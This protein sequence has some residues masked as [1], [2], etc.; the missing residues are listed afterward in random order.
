MLKSIQVKKLGAFLKIKKHF[1]KSVKNGIMV[2][3]VKK[4]GT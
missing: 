3:S 1:K 2:K 4:R